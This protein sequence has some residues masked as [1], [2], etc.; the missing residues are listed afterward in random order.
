M[1]YWLR[2]VYPTSHPS[3]RLSVHTK[4]LSS[5]WDG[6]SL[7]VD[8]LSIFRKSV[9]KIQVSWKSDKNNR[10]FIWRPI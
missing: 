7:N 2:H 4:Q 9:E 5:H 3:V 1:G 10:Y 8:V 6:L